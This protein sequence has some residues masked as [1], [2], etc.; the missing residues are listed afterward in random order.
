MKRSALLITAIVLTLASSC[1]QKEELPYRGTFDEVFI[2]C[3]LGYN[4]LSSALKA[5]VQELSEGYLPSI[6]QRRAVLAYCHNLSKSGGYSTPNGPVLIRLYTKGGA[7]VRDTVKTYDPGTVSASGETL[8]SALGD[9]VHLYPAQRYGMLFSS[10]A[11]GW[12]PPGYATERENSGISF[13]SSAPLAQ[14][15]GDR[16]YPL[17]KSVGAQ[18]SYVKSTL[19]STEIDI[20]DFAAAIPVHLDYLIFDA[21]LMGGAEVA[22]ELRNK[23][24]RLVFSPTE[25]LSNGMVYSTLL[26]HLMGRDEPE[27]EEVCRE[28]Y[29]YYKSQSDSLYQS[30]TISLVDCSAVGEV[31]EAFADIVT[32]C[33]TGFDNLDRSSVQAYFYDDKKWYYDLRDAAREAGASDVQL[34]RLDS[35]LADCVLYHAETRKFF[36]LK[37]ERCCGLS[38]YLPGSRTPKLNAYYRNLG[39]NGATGLLK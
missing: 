26:S 6:S 36:N 37:L 39:W 20:R 29:N 16:I 32:A 28:Y 7:V 12:I 11:T 38:T 35:A 27:L 17:T 22:W 24:D 14:E 8:N 5:D 34:A 10:H 2:Y 1:T 3:G 33:R 13:M 23:C 31:A 15:E 9:I 19:Y 4:N 30:A 18:Y 21:C 25:I